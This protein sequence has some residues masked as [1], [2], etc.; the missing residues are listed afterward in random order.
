MRK[1]LFILYFLFI[2]GVIL[3]QE[4]ILTKEEQKAGFI[5][6]FDGFNLDHWQG[7]K[8]DYIVENGEI[9][10]RP[11]RGGSGN[12]FTRKEYS[13]FVFRFE[14][15]LTA[16]A[17]NGLGIHSPLKGDAAYVGKELQILDN[18]AD[19][20]KDLKPYQ[21][22][23]SVYGLVAAK[24]GFQKPVGEWNQQEVEVRGNQ[25]KITLNGEVILNADLK[26]ATKN[27]TLD[28]KKHP[29]LKKQKGYI[30]FLG[31]GSA[32]QFRNIRILDLSK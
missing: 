20:Y 7:N 24:R 9:W 13:D 5:S 25:I 17:N 27:G 28:G 11:D 10:V 30:G 15:Q 3:S 26:E 2:S 32:L 16:G 14:F 6:L 19:Q 21:Y 18:S 4:T 23:G 22:H 29:G 31:H 12:L 8:T 1:R